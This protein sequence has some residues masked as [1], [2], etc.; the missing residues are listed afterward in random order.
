MYRITSKDIIA[1][2]LSLGKRMWR[3]SYDS[4]REGKK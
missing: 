4:K 3:M 2:S 1:D